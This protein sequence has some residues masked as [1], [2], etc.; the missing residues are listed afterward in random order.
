MPMQWNVKS[1]EHVIAEQHPMAL[2]HIEKFDGENIR[3]TFQFLGSE[4]QRRMLLP[5]SPPLDCRRQCGERRER[6]LAQYAKQVE[7]GELGMKFSVRSG[8]V[9]DHALE[10]VSRRRTQPA[11]EFVDLFFCNHSASSVSSY[12]LPLAPP[13]PE[14]PPPKP[15]KPPPP[16]PKPPPPQPLPPPMPLKSKPQSSSR[17]KRVNSRIRPMI[18]RTAIQPMDS[19]VFG[20]SV[21]GA[22]GRAPVN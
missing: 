3:G 14:L 7:I 20:S 9:E 15:P 12:Q 4:Q 16:P 11:D 19:P 10:I 18:T 2:L 8:T 22:R 21:V 17:P 6:A 1:A 5:A 13:P